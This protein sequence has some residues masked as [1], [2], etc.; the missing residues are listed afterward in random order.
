MGSFEVVNSCCLPFSLF[1][2]LFVLLL[3]VAI[4]YTLAQAYELAVRL[5]SFRRK[6][7]FPGSDIADNAE[8]IANAALK[9]RIEFATKLS[10]ADTIDKTSI[11]FKVDCIE[12][13]FF[14]FW[15][16][17]YAK[18]QS[19]ETLAGLTFIISFLVAALEC[20]NICFGL[21]EE[22]TET[23]KAMAGAGQEVFMFLAIGLFV[24]AFF[25]AVSRLF[26]GILARRRRNWSYLKA[27]FREEFCSQQQQCE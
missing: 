11:L 17:C 9:G 19:I 1:Q 21:R 2:R 18:V 26:K 10:S 27:R 13:R 20:V 12:A 7:E 16:A 8:V 3:L 22:G 5:W 23:I 24:S 6:R 4:V 15:E 25:Y 14:Y